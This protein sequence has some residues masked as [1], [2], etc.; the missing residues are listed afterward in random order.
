MTLCWM[1]CRQKTLFVLFI[2]SSHRQPDGSMFPRLKKSNQHVSC[3]QRRYDTQHNTKKCTTFSKMTRETVMLSVVTFNV[4][5]TPKF[6]QKLSVSL[7]FPNW[8]KCH[9][10]NFL[11]KKRQKML[12]STPPPSRGGGN[13][14]GQKEKDI[15]VIFHRRNFLDCCK[16]GNLTEREF[17]VP[18]TSLY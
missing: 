15:E 9:F 1:P 13:E 14:G 10:N 11:S 12:N 17:S 3:S 2:Y 16:Q 6:W 8:R 7:L 4:V 5:A 18:L